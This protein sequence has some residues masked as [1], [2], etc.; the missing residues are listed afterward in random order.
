MDTNNHSQ[1][2]NEKE[3]QEKDKRSIW[4]RRICL[5]IA[6]ILLILL[7][8]RFCG[9]RDR[10]VET[11]HRPDTVEAGPG[12]IDDTALEGMTDEEI[13]AALNRQVQE[14]MMTMTMNP[15]PT[16]RNGKG[17]LLIHND[18]T[19]HGPIVV[20]IRRNDTNDLIYTSPIIPLGKRVN[21]GSLN[22][23][24]PSGVYPC[25]ALFHYVDDTGAILG[26]GGVAVT[27]HIVD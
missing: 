24:L 5:L 15:D 14:S 17:N 4:V 13:V 1:Q 2:P 26:S 25:T 6:I 18:T 8:L 3:E 9:S 12:G 11:D 16:F 21:F 23:E 20:E 10:M 19:N 7:M 27:D 22:T